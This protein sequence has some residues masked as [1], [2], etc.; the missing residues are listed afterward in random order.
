MLKS[1]PKIPNILFVTSVFVC[2]PAISSDKDLIGC[3]LNKSMTA[4]FSDGR[5]RSNK[6]AVCSTEFQK[7]KIVSECVGADGR[8]VLEYS[9][10]VVEPG[11]YKSTLTSHSHR[12]DLVGFS[13]LHKYRFVG[14]ELHI[15]SKPPIAR[16]APAVHAVLI[17]SVSER[18]QCK[19]AL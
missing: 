1:A 4:H 19:K 9:W 6:N 14:E 15:S 13:S 11:V 5:S 7:E 8:S 17:E 10:S 16:P 3:W 2:A 12:Q 18:V